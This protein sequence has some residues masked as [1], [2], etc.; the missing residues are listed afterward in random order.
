[1][2]TKSAVAYALALLLL[3]GQIS[4][5]PLPWSA[6]ISRFQGIRDNDIEVSIRQ[7][8]TQAV[9][10]TLPTKAV[11]VVSSK[12][13]VLMTDTGESIP[14]K[15]TAKA[16]E[17]TVS[18]P[19]FLKEIKQSVAMPIVNVKPLVK[20]NSKPTVV[21]N[22][23]VLDLGVLK[24][25]SVGGK[26]V[27]MRIGDKYVTL[28][29]E[30]F[31]NFMKKMNPKEAD[32]IDGMIQSANGK[33]PVIIEG[34]GPIKSPTDT[35]KIPEIPKPDIPGLKDKLKPPMPQ[36]DLAKDDKID[37][38]KFFPKIEELRDR[39]E[40]ATINLGSI[41]SKDI[42]ETPQPKVTQPTQPSPAPYMGTSWT[43]TSPTQSSAPSHDPSIDMIKKLF[44]CFPASATVTTADGRKLRMDQL[45]EGMYV[46]SNGLGGVSRVFGFS[47]RDSTAR[48][49]FVRLRT[50]TGNE[51]MLTPGH[52]LPINGEL[53][54][55]SNLRAG[56]TVI[57]AD[58]TCSKVIRV[59]T[60][61]DEGLYNPHTL[62]GSIVVDGVVASTFTTAVKPSVARALLAPV[63]AIFRILGRNL[64][65]PFLNGPC[66]ALGLLASHMLGW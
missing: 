57:L 51:L 40:P 26:D 15:L 29:V 16:V 58:G 20:K 59:E 13:G 56:D 54:P 4:A 21:N 44:E 55:A 10:P 53:Q 23:V 24:P 1:M 50:T 9:A 64:F 28:N 11:T 52:F 31:M 35:F 19:K 3:V 66:V 36:L 37:I 2:A 46:V 27:K 14:M 41:I 12:N 43:H 34:D 30:D 7:S 18:K 65:G 60:V 25:S 17:E 8:T 61:W 62:D 22:K 38:S 49:E 39:M 32:E 33:L 63:A 45:T 47:H 6:W 42:S 5:I 48:S